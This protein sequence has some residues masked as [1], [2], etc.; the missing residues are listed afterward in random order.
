VVPQVL[1]GVEVLEG[2]AR[3]EVARVK[4]ASHWSY[5]PAC[6]R[7]QDLGDVLKL[8]YLILSEIKEWKGTQI[9]LTSMLWEELLQLRQDLGPR[10]HFLWRVL[11]SRYGA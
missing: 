7:H 4:E 5:L 8:G 6:P 1:R 2:Q 3:K 9:L 11:N 10:G